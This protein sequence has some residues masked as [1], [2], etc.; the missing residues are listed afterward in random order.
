MLIQFGIIRMACGMT[1]VADCIAVTLS[2]STAEVSVF[3]KGQ[4]VLNLPQSR[5]R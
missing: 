2:Q 1:A 5:T 4:L 3:H